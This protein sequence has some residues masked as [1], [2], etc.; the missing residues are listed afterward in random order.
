MKYMGKDAEMI[1]VEAGCSAE[2]H[3]E[4][5]KRVAGRNVIQLNGANKIDGTYVIRAIVEIE[6]KRKLLLEG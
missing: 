6:N 1:T 5:E 2:A 4:L 3:E